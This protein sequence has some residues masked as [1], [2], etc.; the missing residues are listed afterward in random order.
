MPGDSF[1]TTFNTAAPPDA[2]ADLLAC[3]AS[4]RWAAEIVA[5]RPY[6]D[7]GQLAE[8]S[9]KTLAGLDWTDVREALDAHPR[10]GDRAAGAGRE[11]GWSR[12]EQSAAATA[13]D[14]VRADLVAGNIRYEEQFGHVF[15]ICATGLSAATVLANLRRRLGNDSVAERDEVRAELGRIVALRLG[16]LAES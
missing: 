10:I 9:A 1:L 13:D 15:L 2:T 4:H 8:V 7:F 5:G 6:R 12:A 14:R 11:A 16:K 3:C